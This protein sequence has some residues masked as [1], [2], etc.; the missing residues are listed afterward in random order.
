MRVTVQRFGSKHGYDVSF[1]IDVDGKYVCSVQGDQLNPKGLSI[2][3][4]T[5]YTGV[6]E[7]ALRSAVEKEDK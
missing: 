5:R 7:A 3:E 4:A 1:R 2:N 6:I